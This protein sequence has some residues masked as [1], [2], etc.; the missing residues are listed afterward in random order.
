MTSLCAIRDVLEAT[1]DAQEAVLVTLDDGDERR[2]VGGREWWPCQETRGAC[3]LAWVQGTYDGF[4]RGPLE[5]CRLHIAISVYSD[6]VSGVVGARWDH[7][8]LP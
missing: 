1:R 6:P 5:N 2:G 8:R 3:W 4:I 7:S